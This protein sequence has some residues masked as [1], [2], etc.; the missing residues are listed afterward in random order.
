MSYL[1]RTDDVPRAE[2]REFWRGVV[3][4]AFV[5]LAASFPAEAD[6]AF[7]G[8]LRGGTLGP[9]GIFDVDTDAHA[10]HR[11]RR[12]ISAHPADYY[13]LGLLVRGNG[14]LSQD[15]RQA[16]LGPGDFAV[17]DTSR[18]YT[19]AFDSPARLLVLIFPRPMLALRP[20]AIERITATTISG[21]TGLG[22]LISPFLLRMGHDLEELEERG[23]VRLAA[24]V[25]DLLSTALADRLDVRAPDPSGAL[26]LRITTFIESRLGDPLLDPAAIAA[27]HHISTRYLH[28]LFHSEG[29]SVSVWIRERRLGRCR[30]DLLDPLLRDRSVSTIAAR[31]GFVNAAHFSRLFKAVYGHSPRECRAGQTVCAPG[32]DVTGAVP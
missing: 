15:G 2:R 10:A 27:A 7:S 12:L 19:L 25:L 6:G 5:P 1:A 29:T 11:T 14:V 21:T 23:G 9:L 3:S 4:D 20:R 28:K 32:Q 18:P 22:A 26:F 31:W 13:K 24:N 16:R 30:R 17:Y 8:R